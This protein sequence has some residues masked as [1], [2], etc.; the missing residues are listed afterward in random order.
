[1]CVKINGAHLCFSFA[2]FCYRN[3]ERMSFEPSYAR[4]I[5]LLQV[6]TETTDF[7]TQTTDLADDVP[8]EELITG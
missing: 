7:L 4:L 6:V 8:A 1:M 5:V 2:N 3:T